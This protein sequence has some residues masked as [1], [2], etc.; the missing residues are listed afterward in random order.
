MVYTSSPGTEKWSIQVV[1]VR[2]MVCL[3]GWSVHTVHELH[4]VVEA[5]VLHEV[6]TYE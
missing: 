3:P 1:K 4:H 2:K 6:S 5:L